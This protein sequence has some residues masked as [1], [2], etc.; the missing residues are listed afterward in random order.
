MHMQTANTDLI[1]RFYTAF[2]ALDAETMSA[3]YSN[4]VRF[5]DPAFGA[6]HGRE[7]GDMWRMLLGRANDFTL[8][9]DD[10]KVVGQA[11]TA[12]AVARYTYSGSGRFV[13]NTIDSRFEIRNGLIAEQIDS[14]DLWRWSRQALGVKGLLFGWSTRMQEEI[15]LRARRALKEYQN[16]AS[17]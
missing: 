4:D 16:K 3:C 10:V 17:A 11:A 12:K 9:V 6:L 5:T 2:Q 14:F 7:V 13:V 15:N 1:E 8:S